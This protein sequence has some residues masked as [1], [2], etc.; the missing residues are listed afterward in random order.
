MCILEQQA[1]LWS[2]LDGSRREVESRAGRP[3]A[4]PGRRGRWGRDGAPVMAAAVDRQGWAS[5]G[6]PRGILQGQV[7][8][9]GVE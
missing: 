8:T 3:G 9:G 2:E 7:P 4:Q 5:R 1:G 6:P